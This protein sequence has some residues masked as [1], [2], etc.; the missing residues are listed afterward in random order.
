MIAYISCQV[1]AIALEYPSLDSRNLIILTERLKQLLA[2]KLYAHSCD[3][4]SLL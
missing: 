2:D 3:Y 1:S 4:S